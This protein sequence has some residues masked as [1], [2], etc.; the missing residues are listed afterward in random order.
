M[1]RLDVSEDTF[2]YVGLG[3][4]MKFGVTAR[5]N[6]IVVKINEF[7]FF[8]LWKTPRQPDFLHQ[9][10]DVTRTYQ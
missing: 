3:L 1:N 2:A 10:E 9:R 7:R 4:Y 8:W 6:F 5:P